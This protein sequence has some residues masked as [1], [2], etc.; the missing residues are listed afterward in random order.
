MGYCG[1]HLI[2]CHLNVHFTASVWGNRWVY[3]VGRL[4]KEL[5]LFMGPGWN[6]GGVQVKKKIPVGIFHNVP[7][8]LAFCP[9]R[10]ESLQQNKE[11]LLWR[12]PLPGVDCTPLLCGPGSGAA[13]SLVC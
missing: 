9:G 3:I 11:A 13:G 5:F 6:S 4:S 10:E 12:R 7:V 2:C 1:Y 8:L